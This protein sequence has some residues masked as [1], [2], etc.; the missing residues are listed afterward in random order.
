[1][2]ASGYFYI[3]KKL[4]FLVQEQSAKVFLE[5]SQNSQESTCVR[6]SFLKR[7]SGRCFPVNF[8]NFLRTPFLTEHLRWLLLLVLNPNKG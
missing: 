7:D 2:P 1:M 6:A 8:A 3:L 4:N 5:I